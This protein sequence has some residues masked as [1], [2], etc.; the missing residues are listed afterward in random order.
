MAGK[1]IPHYHVLM[2]L[3]GCMPDVNQVYD[4][5]DQA[6]NGAQEWAEVCRQD[7]DKVV[8]NKQAG[9][10]NETMRTYIEVTTRCFDGCM[11]RCPECGTTYDTSEYACWCCGAK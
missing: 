7:G 4:T 2:G 6:R 10:Q 8:G 9:Y 1:A 5:V 3:P 11:V